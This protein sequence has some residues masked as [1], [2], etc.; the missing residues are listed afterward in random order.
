MTKLPDGL[1]AWIASD[2]RSPACDADLEEGLA[3]IIRTSDIRDQAVG[4]AVARMDMRVDKP[5]NDETLSRID[6]SVDVA[7]EVLTDKEDRIAFEN[8]IGISQKDMTA[9]T[10]TDQPSARDLRSHQENPVR[11]I[12]TPEWSAYLD[13]SNARN[14]RAA[15][16]ATDP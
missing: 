13:R 15:D 16:L 9:E 5:G 1:I 11:A 3:K 4:G 8:Q 2:P 14:W 6:N 12:L 7:R 10:I